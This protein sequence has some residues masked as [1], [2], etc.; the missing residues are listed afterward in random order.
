[1]QTSAASRRFVQCQVADKNTLNSY[2][3]R[4]AIPVPFHWM[5][6]I[7]HRWQM[8]CCSLPPWR[9]APCIYQLCRLRFMSRL[10]LLLDSGSTNS[11]ISQHLLSQLSL[12]SDE[13][14]TYHMNTLDRSGDVNSRVVSITV[15]PCNDDATYSLDK[16]LVTPKIPLE[17]ICRLTLLIMFTC[18]TCWSIRYHRM[19]MLTYLSAWIMDIWS[20][21][22]R[23]A[24]IC[25]VKINCMH[26]GLS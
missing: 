13:S 25:L 26:Q 24:V 20:R 21:P 15:S 14:A 23:Y 7:S 18:L 8:V 10:F 2:S 11:F 3:L 17:E 19:F 16:V 4:C 6:L 5:N 9:R 22:M 1:M 12:R